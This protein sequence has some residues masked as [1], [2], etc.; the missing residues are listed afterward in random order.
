[1]SEFIVKISGD[2][3][4]YKQDLEA[5]DKKADDTD[6]RVQRTVQNSMIAMRIIL[7]TAALVTVATGEKIDVAFLMMVSMMTSSLMSLKSQ[8]AVFAATPGMQ[9]FAILLSTMIP[10][11]TATMLWVKSE[12]SKLQ[13][14]MSAQREADL[15]GVLDV[16]NYNG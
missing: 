1:M 14:Q 10:M 16:V 7:D 2:A 13:T 15:D 4:Q 5:V 3:S 6:K 12:Q 9:P 11:L 8:I